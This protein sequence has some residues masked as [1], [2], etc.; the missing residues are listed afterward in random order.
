MYEVNIDDEELLDWIISMD[1]LTFHKRSEEMLKMKEQ[2][3]EHP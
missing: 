3:M 1:K 2:R